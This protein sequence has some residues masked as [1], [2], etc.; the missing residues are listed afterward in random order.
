MTEMHFSLE[1]FTQDWQAYLAQ[2]KAAGGDFE[3]LLK[4][5]A[6]LDVTV[7]DVTDD[8]EEEIGFN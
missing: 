8:G 5:R 4:E 7:L 1:E 2:Y 6:R 3:A